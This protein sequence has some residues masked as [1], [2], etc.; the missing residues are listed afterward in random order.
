MNIL[1]FATIELKPNEIEKIILEYV[2]KETKMNVESIKFITRTET[3]G[4]GPGEYDET[5][6]SGCTIKLTE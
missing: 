4:Y 2:Q 1:K 3:H 6:F 5:V